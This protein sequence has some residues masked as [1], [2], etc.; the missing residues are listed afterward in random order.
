[1]ASIDGVEVRGELV[2]L[3]GAAERLGVI[4]Q[5][6]NSYAARKRAGVRSW[7]PFPDPV[8]KVLGSP[9]YRWADIDAWD[10]ARQRRST[11]RPD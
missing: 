10:K 11:Q 3:T 1:M 6:L 8:V 9:L 2:S 4:V 7:N 5:S